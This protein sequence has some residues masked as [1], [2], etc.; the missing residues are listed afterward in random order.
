MD[1]PNE[2]NPMD[3]LLFREPF[4]GFYRN[5]R[6]WVTGHT[7]FK[8]SWLSAWLVELGAKVTGY[9]MNPPSEPAHFDELGLKKRMKDV[10]SDIRDAGRVKK[11]MAKARPEIVFHLAAQP[12]VRSSYDDP[13]ATYQTNVMG[14][15]HV[16]E[17]IRHQ[18]GIR[19]AVI[20]TS[21]KCYENVE[22]EAGYCEGDRLGGKD[23][24]SASKA[25][26]EIAFSSYARSFFTHG[27][28]GIAT[29]RAGNVIGGGDWAKD[30]IVPD[31]IRAWRG[32][33]KPVVRNPRSTRPWQHVLEP[34]SGYLALA[35]A[36]ATGSGVHA[37][38][39]G[40]SKVGHP[41]KNY[42]PQG[43]AFNFGPRKDVNETVGSLIRELRKHWPMARESKIEKN[44]SKPEAGLLQL[45]CTKARKLL[46][47]RAT[48]NFAETA[49]FTAKWYRSFFENDE[50]TWR[51]TSNQIRNYVSLARI[52][53]LP[54]AS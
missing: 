10:R 54:W 35:A 11:A 46:G 43:E 14:T 17:A 22:Q 25:A 28:T 8:G 52:R 51:L 45:D 3:K 1:P 29:A 47:W 53:K 32:K 31:C 21:D 13:M 33:K 5:K 2:M 27:K 38:A 39:K 40:F 30:R 4:R 26:A 9:A 48:L 36:L 12:I 6:V 37:L 42:M 7:G 50:S 15:I 41:R 18:S 20:V 34:I 23:P 16:L 44:K 19:A 49:S 24:Y